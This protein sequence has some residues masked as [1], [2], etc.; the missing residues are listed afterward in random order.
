MPTTD[1]KKRGFAAMDPALVRAIAKKGGIAA[2]EAG[3]AHEFSAAEA[4]VAGS[5]GGKAAHAKNREHTLPCSK[6]HC[7]I[8]HKAAAPKPDDPCSRCGGSGNDPEI[9]DCV[10]DCCQGSG[11]ES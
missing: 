9:K 4:K 1:K 8:C 10:C 11:V 2:H 6:T 7:K 3:T 5:K